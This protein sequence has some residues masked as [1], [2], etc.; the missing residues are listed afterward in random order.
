MMP[1]IN[2]LALMHHI[3]RGMSGSTI[4]TWDQ[5]LEFIIT[6]WKNRYLQGFSMIIS[7]EHKLND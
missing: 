3:H 5:L 1:V 6:S 2:M 4:Q 7:L